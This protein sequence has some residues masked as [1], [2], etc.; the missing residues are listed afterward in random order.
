M[1]T[2]LTTAV[3]FITEQMVSVLGIVTAEPVFCLGIAVWVAGA[4]IGLFK[5][6]V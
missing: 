6:L 1:P 2:A 4:G 3:T 5:R